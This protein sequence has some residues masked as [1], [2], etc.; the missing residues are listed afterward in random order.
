M[1]FDGSVSL[2]RQ[3][4]AASHRSHSGY[5]HNPF[6]G[7]RGTYELWNQTGGRVFCSSHRRFLG[8]GQ[9]K[10]VK[11]HNRLV[12]GTFA[13]GEVRS[14]RDSPGYWTPSTRRKQKSSEQFQ[15]FAVV[16]ANKGDVSRKGERDDLISEAGGALR[17]LVT[18]D[19]VYHI[20]E[21]TTDVN[22]KEYLQE[23]EEPCH[24]SIHFKS[25]ERYPDNGISKSQSRSGQ[26]STVVG[27]WLVGLPDC[28][29]THSHGNQT[30]FCF[31]S[32]CPK[33]ITAGSKEGPCRMLVLCLPNPEK[34]LSV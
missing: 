22:E 15:G 6:D 25:Q 9:L 34:Q 12:R 16:E 5:E 28:E 4:S 14:G 11:L 31:F 24:H 8:P 18:H 19:P 30:P 23:G 10:C 33:T 2:G 20:L 7:L 3:T 32:V 1:S 29:T 13:S 26:H 17:T 21:S 27:E